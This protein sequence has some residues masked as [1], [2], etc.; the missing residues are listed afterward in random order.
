MRL[1]SYVTSNQTPLCV[2]RWTAMLVLASLVALPAIGQ[3]GQTGSFITV[4]VLSTKN[5]KPLKGVIV[6]LSDPSKK[7]NKYQAT[8]IAHAQTNRDGVAVLELPGVIPEEVMAYIAGG[9]CGSVAECSL[10]VSFSTFEIIKRGIVASMCVSGKTMP[11]TV[12]PKP[13]E[14]VIFGAPLT[15]KDCA[16]REIP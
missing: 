7:L 14:L 3:T 16:A 9:P 13:G 12:T 15:R 10:G 11:Y 5:G 8:T 2:T 6:T 1:F 4:L